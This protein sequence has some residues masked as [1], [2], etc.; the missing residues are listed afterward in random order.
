LVGAGPGDPELLTLKAVRYLREADVVLYDDL[1]GDGIL[2]FARREA[3]KI[4]VGKRGGRTSCKQEDITALAVLLAQEGNRVVRLKGGD[5]LIFGRAD[6]EIA[7]AEHAG[8]PITVI[9][10][11]SAAQGAA[12]AMG[13]SLTKRGVARRIQFVTAHSETGKIPRR[14]DWTS[15]ADPEVTTCIYMGRKTLGQFLEKALRAGLD[16]STSAR[17]VINATRGDQ[18]VLKG[19]VRSIVGQVENCTKQGAGVMMIGRVFDAQLGHEKQTPPSLQ[20]AAE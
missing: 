5:P 8:I 1:V 17:F 13:I 19:S 10:G 12:A 3:R 2:G 14:M 15:I 7:A 20:V 18:H 4:L 16:P 6:E 11:I 9:S